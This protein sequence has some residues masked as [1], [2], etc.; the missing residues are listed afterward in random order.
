MLI[1]ASVKKKAHLSNL[2][3]TINTSKL[4]FPINTKHSFSYFVYIYTIVYSKMYNI[5]LFAVFT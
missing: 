1:P 2:H 3:F 5:A 4:Q